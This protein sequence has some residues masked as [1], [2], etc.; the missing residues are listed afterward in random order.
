M[1]FTRY[2]ERDKM[3]KDNHY[4]IDKSNTLLKKITKLYFTQLK[5]SWIYLYKSGKLFLKIHLA[6]G[7][8]EENAISVLPDGDEEKITIFTYLTSK[9]L[10]D[11]LTEILE[12]K[13]TTKYILKLFKE[14]N[15]D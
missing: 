2:L 9:K 7:I 3:V 4:Y 11:I 15:N 1:R 10:Y 8:I 14:G 6:N 5:G 12:E 13:N